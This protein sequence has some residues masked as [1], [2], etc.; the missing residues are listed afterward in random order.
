MPC[1]KSDARPADH[2]KRDGGPDTAA[3]LRSRSFPKIDAKTNTNFDLRF[4][5]KRHAKGVKAPRQGGCVMACILRIERWTMA[6][7]EDAVAT[8][9]RLLEEYQVPTPRL[10]ARVVGGLLEIS[11]CFPTDPDL[12]V[13]RHI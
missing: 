7:A 2:A 5:F 3:I 12:H 10:D 6:E 9:W 1:V 11:I 8:L 4:P 13:V